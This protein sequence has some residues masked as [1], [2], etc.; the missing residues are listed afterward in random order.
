MSVISCY[1][2]VDYGKAIKKGKLQEYVLQSVTVFILTIIALKRI[3]LK[4]SLFMIEPSKKIICQ[5]GKKLKNILLQDIFSNLTI[6]CFLS[7]FI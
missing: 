6:F 2:Y 4:L 5:F 3:Y 1:V 7:E